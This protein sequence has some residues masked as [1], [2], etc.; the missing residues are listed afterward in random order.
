MVPASR[1]IRLFPRFRAWRGKTGGAC[2]LI[3][4]RA[5]SVSHPMLWNAPG[6]GR[7]F[8][9]SCRFATAEKNNTTRDDCHGEFDTPT[10][11]AHDSKAHDRARF[12]PPLVTCRARPIAFDQARPQRSRLARLALVPRLSQFP[13]ADFSCYW[14][15]AGRGSFCQARRATGEQAPWRLACASAGDLWARFTRTHAS[16]PMEESEGDPTRSLA[17]ARVGVDSRYSVVK[18]ALRSSMVCLLLVGGLFCSSREQAGDRSLRWPTTSSFC[19]PESAIKPNNRPTLTWA[20]RPAVAAIRLALRPAAATSGW[21]R[22]ECRAR[23]RWPA[24]AVERAGGRGRRAA[25]SA[26]RNAA[27]LEAAG[28][29]HA[30][31]TVNRR[32]LALP[33]EPEEEDEGPPG[34]MTLDAAINQL[35]RQNY[36]LRTKWMEIP[37]ARADVLTA[38]LRANPLVFGSVSSIPY[39]SIRRSGPAR[40]TIAGR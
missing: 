24:I 22:R 23:G 11:P 34:G 13:H 12:R 3:A 33:D 40:P 37:Q 18:S 8:D 4:W 6:A 7:K 35:V 9:S 29:D 14:R 16:T 30:V 17:C 2:G 32:A 39:G 1:F 21:V 26:G 25:I 28:I 19:R 36:D 10:F 27:L 38:S 20:G 5:P 31:A 15:C